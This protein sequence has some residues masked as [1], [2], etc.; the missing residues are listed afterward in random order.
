MQSIYM[1]NPPDVKRVYACAE[2]ILKT[3]ANC[4]RYLTRDDVLAGN[5]KDVEYIFATW[6]MPTFTEEEIRSFLPSLKTVF[7]A[8]G[9]VRY[10]AEPFLKCGVRVHSAWAANAIPVA[11]Y[12]VAQIILANKG[13]YMTAY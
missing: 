1:G 6:G 2:A 11:E 5:A 7:Y 9:T 13:Y 12:A 10:F 8:A 3:E 4:D